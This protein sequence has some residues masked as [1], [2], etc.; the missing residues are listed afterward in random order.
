[1]S[2]LALYIK[3][4]D[5]HRC[6]ETLKELLKEQGIKLLEINNGIVKIANPQNE[7]QLSILKDYITSRGFE[8]IEDNNQKIV[9]RIKI[10]ANVWI[11]SKNKQISILNFSDFVSSKLRMNYRYLST[12]FSETEKTTIE[13]YLIQEKIRKVKELLIENRM[14]LNEIAFEL[15]YS[16]SAHLSRQFK[17]FAHISPIQFKNELRVELQMCG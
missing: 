16:S 9:E 2:T 5:C 17:Q 1:M 10:L 12:L 7:T 13:K 14:N 15:G 6:L 11:N 8:L 4:I 3:N